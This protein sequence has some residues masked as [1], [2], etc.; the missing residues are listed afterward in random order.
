MFVFQKNGL[1][2]MRSCVTNAL[3]FQQMRGPRPTDT[4]QLHLPEHLM[5][6]VFP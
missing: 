1:K 3:H 2:K 6:E 5:E 4:S